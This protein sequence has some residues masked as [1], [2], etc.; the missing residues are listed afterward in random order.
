MRKISRLSVSPAKNPATNLE[1]RVTC[2]RVLFSPRLGV[3]KDLRLA[4]RIAVPVKLAWKYR[5]LNA[6]C[7]ATRRSDLLEYPHAR[8]RRQSHIAGDVVPSHDLHRLDALISNAL[9]RLK[10]DDFNCSL[11]ARKYIPGHLQRSVNSGLGALVPVPKIDICRPR[12]IR[13][14][15]GPHHLAIAGLFWN[16]SRIK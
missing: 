7:C 4:Y 9:P 15:P 13:L 12:H 2:A 10:S 16:L 6:G 1:N 8:Y 14:V 5:P 11:V 3:R